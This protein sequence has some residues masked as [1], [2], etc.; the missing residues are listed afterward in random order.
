MRSLHFA[1]W[2]GRPRP[3]VIVSEDGP[4]LCDCHPERG[5]TPES[6]DPYPAAPSTAAP[7]S[8]TDTVS[9]LCSCGAGALARVCHRER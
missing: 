3:R 1:L 7:G 2:R 6:K 9:A 5:H 4:L 8:F